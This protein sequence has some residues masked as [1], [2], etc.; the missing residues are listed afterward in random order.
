[1][2]RRGEREFAWTRDSNAPSESAVFA[3]VLRRHYNL[4]AALDFRNARATRRRRRRNSLAA[5]ALE[6]EAAAATEGIKHGHAMILVGD[7]FRF[8]DAGGVFEAWER[9]LAWYDETF[10]FAKKTGR[11]ARTR[12]SEPPPLALP[13]LALGA[14]EAGDLPHPRGFGSAG[15]RLRSTSS[16]RGEAS[17]RTRRP[18]R[19]CRADS[20]RTPITFRTGKTRGWARTSRGG[21]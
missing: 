16:P 2:V 20:S 5:A 3:H 1:M 7:D 21:R 11:G 9:L 8:D 4:P 10:F 17:R 18:F 13:P 6:A 12:R 14:R 19:A 15:R